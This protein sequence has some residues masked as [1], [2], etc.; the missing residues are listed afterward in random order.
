MIEINEHSEHGILALKVSGTLTEDELEELVP[1]LE[2]HIS[3]STH[4][5]LLMIMDDFD[6]WENAAAAW[7]DLQLDAKYIGYFD[8]IAIIGEKKWQKWGT[9]LVD[10]LTSEELKFF[11]IEQA[12]NAWEWISKEHEEI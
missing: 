1:S 9:R 2:E 10:P 8:R 12:D 11:P 6:G 3:E 7:K 5:H 4:P